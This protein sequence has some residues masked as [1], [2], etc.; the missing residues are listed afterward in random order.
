MKIFDTLLPENHTHSCTTQHTE[1]IF[2]APP[3][4]GTHS[5]FYIIASCVLLYTRRYCW[6]TS[7][8]SP[9]SRA[10]PLSLMPGYMFSSNPT[11]KWVH[12][13]IIIIEWHKRVLFNI[14]N[15]SFP[16]PHTKLSEML[17][18]HNIHVCTFVRTEMRMTR[19][20]V[21]LF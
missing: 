20:F 17:K 7:S 2:N 9:P 21:S 5:C 10:P 13:I 1:I 8:S 19:V 15:R 11:T 18:T 4:T 12:N 16:H 3:H 14:H 6:I